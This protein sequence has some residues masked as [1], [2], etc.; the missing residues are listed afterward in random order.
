MVTEEELLLGIDEN[1]ASDLQIQAKD[2]LAKN[3]LFST[4][5][6]EAD[7]VASLKIFRKSL[8]INDIR[9]AKAMLYNNDILRKKVKLLAKKLPIQ[10]Q[11]VGRE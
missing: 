8:T 6:K 9:F 3:S 7:R 4:L 5:L 10:A 2:Y 1:K 11:R